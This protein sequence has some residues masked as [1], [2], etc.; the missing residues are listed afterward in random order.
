[1]YLYIYISICIYIYIYIYIYLNQ[2]FHQG[3]GGGGG[4]VGLRGIK[5]L[6]HPTPQPVQGYLADKKP[7]LYR[8]NSLIRNRIW[9]TPN[10]NPYRGTPLIRNR[11]LL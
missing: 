2:A 6:V 8:G 5:D 10:L 9:Y 1:M 11:V 7:P 4:G 3:G